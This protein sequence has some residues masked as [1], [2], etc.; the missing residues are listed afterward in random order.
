MSLDYNYKRWTIGTRVNYFGQVNLYGY[1]DFASLL[2][3]VPTD[4]DENVRVADLYLYKPK[5]VQDVYASARIINGL[6]LYLGLDNIWNEHPDLG[7]VPGAAGWAYNNETG[8][9]W[10]AV[11]MGGNGRKLFARLGFNF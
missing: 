4:A 1:G 9:P 2:P 6:T 7:Y 3:E 8:G 11:Q 5:W 10:D